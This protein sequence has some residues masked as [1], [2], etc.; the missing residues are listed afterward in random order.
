IGTFFWQLPSVERIPAQTKEELVW[1]ELKPSRFFADEKGRGNLS[2]GIRAGMP[3][4]RCSFG[5]AELSVPDT[6]CSFRNRVRC[7]VP[8]SEQLQVPLLEN[9][10]YLNG[11]YKERGAV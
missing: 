6:R 7:A 11:Q 5:N 2:W 1:G 4:R 10:T 3:D 9:L 8:R